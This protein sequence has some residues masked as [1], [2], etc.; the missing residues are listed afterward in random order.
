[1]ATRSGDALAFDV[2][3]TL[4][5]APRVATLD[6]VSDYVEDRWTAR[7]LGEIDLPPFL[8]RD[9]ARD[10]LRAVRSARRMRKRELSDMW[11]CGRPQAVRK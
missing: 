5:G 2:M 4:L 8:D 1:M 10:I 11:A 7:L 9:D 3:A 6:N